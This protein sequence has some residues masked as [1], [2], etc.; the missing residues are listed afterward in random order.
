M[1]TPQIQIYLRRAHKILF[2]VLSI[3]KFKS[4]KFVSLTDNVPSETA[5]AVQRPHEIRPDKTGSDSPPEQKPT[6]LSSPF[7]LASVLSL[8][9]F[10]ANTQHEFIDPPLRMCLFSYDK[11]NPDHHNI[12]NRNAGP[13]GRT[14]C[15][16]KPNGAR[17]ADDSRRLFIRE[18]ARESRGSC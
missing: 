9:W 16:Q 15:V 11:D 17:T 1:H 8:D 18:L 7:F 2:A 13:V 14:A 10:F 5:T 4:Q 6:H 3:T 12:A